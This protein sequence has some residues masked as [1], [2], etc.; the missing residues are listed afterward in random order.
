M[1]KCISID[2]VHNLQTNIFEAHNV[3]DYKFEHCIPKVT[4][5]VCDDNDTNINDMNNIDYYYIFDNPGQDAFCHWVYESFIFYPVFLSLVEKYNNIKILTK[6]KKKYVSNFFTLFNIKNEICY[7]V[8]NTNNICFLSLPIISL[9]DN[10]I[11]VDYF[12][13]YLKLFI[14]NLNLIIMK[15]IFEINVLLCPR[16]TKDNY[17]GNDRII[18]GI[19]DIENNVVGNGG[20]VLNTYNINNLMIQFTLVNSCKTI[21][22]DYGSSFFINCIFISGRNIILLDNYNYYDKQVKH[23]KAMKILYDEINNKNKINLVKAK[24]KTQ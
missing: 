20:C 24:K 16:N 12:T 15:N 2:E 6:N 14:A 4:L 1:V 11:N 19:D 22:L 5:N 21:I 17:V 23:F 7:E 10:N 3:S 18:K 8:K 9:N 13:K